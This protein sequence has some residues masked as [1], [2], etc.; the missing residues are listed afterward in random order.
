MLIVDDALLFP[1][2]S[3]FWIFREVHN[4]AEQELAN[5]SEAIT[6]E[7]SELYMMLETG[8]IDEE[9]FD[10]R[11]K[12]LLARLDKLQEQ[13]H[14]TDLRDEAAGDE[15]QEEDKEEA[16]IEE[17]LPQCATQMVSRE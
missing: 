8:R 10:A 3:I 2:R 7:L 13:E 6:A 1:V 9:E 12:A 14:G 5:E 17:S 11:E 15:E 4:A 16:K